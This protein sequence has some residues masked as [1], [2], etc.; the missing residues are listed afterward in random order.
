MSFAYDDSTHAA[1]VLSPEEIELFGAD[2]A[3]ERATIVP[4]WPFK[5]FEV[6]GPELKFL[7]GLHAEN[8]GGSAFVCSIAYD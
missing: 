4:F 6:A 5:A 2:L 3:K 1:V 7:D 8:A